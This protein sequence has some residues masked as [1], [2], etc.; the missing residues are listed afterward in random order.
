MNNRIKRELEVHRMVNEEGHIAVIEAM[1]QAIQE[2]NG[3]LEMIYDLKQL[4]KQY[5]TNRIEEYDNMWKDIC[6]N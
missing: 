6:N 1:I 4:K 5:L 3:D 2:T